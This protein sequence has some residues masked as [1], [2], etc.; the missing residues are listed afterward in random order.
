MSSSAISIF[1]GNVTADPTSK[2][3]GNTTLTNFSLAINRPSKGG[4]EE[5]SFFD[6]Q[7]WDGEFSKPASSIAEHVKKGKTLCI[8]ATPQ[9]DRW[10]GEDGKGRSKVVFRVNKWHFVGAKQND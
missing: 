5:T 9:Q 7:A 10:D 3:I 4:E 2:P 6:F 1:V 8:H